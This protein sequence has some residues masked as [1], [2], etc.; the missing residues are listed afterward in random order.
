MKLL[1]SFSFLAFIFLMS[2][3]NSGEAQTEKPNEKL[4][5]QRTQKITNTDDSAMFFRQ[6]LSFQERGTIQFEGATHF[7]VSSINTTKI[8]TMLNALKERCHNLEKTCRQNDFVGD[9]FIHFKGKKEYYL[10][11]VVKC[12]K[13]DAYVPEPQNDIQRQLLSAYMT[14][15]RIN[16]TFLAA[17]YYLPYMSH[18][19]PRSKLQLSQVFRKRPLIK[20]GASPKKTPD[21]AAHWD[22]IADDKGT[23]FYIDKS[24]DLTFITGYDKWQENAYT[25]DTYRKDPIR[26][27]I[28]CIIVCQKKHPVLCR[29]ELK[30]IRKQYNMAVDRFIQVAGPNK[31]VEKVKPPSLY[32][33]VSGKSTK[34]S[35]PRNSSVTAPAPSTRSKRQIL[36]LAAPLLQFFLPFLNDGWYQAQVTSKLE[37]LETQ[38]ETLLEVMKNLTVP[39]GKPKEIAPVVKHWNSYKNLTMSVAATSA[40]IVRAVDELDDYISPARYHLCPLKIIAEI[41][42]NQEFQNRLKQR[43]LLAHLDLSTLSCFLLESTSDQHV[44]RLYTRVPTTNF[45]KYDLVQTLNVPFYTTHGPVQPFLTFEYFAV[46][47]SLEKVYPIYDISTCK[48]G[49]CPPPTLSYTSRTELC[50]V[51]QFY[52]QTLNTCVLQPLSNLSPTATVTPEGFAILSLPLDQTYTALSSCDNDGDALES[53]QMSLSGLTHL[54]IPRQCFVHIQT[55]GMTIR[56]PPEQFFSYDGNNKVS[57]VQHKA[58]NHSAQHASV[59]LLH[60]LKEQHNT[61]TTILWTAFLLLAGS[62]LFFTSF[63]IS[64][65]YCTLT[66]ARRFRNRVNMHLQHFYRRDPDLDPPTDLEATGIIDSTPILSQRQTY[67]PSTMTLNGRYSYASLTSMVPNTEVDNHVELLQHRALPAFEIGGACRPLPDFADPPPET[68]SSEEPKYTTI[69]KSRQLRGSS[70][71]LD[72]VK[73]LTPPATAAKPKMPGARRKL[74]ADP[75]IRASAGNLDEPPPF[76]E[77][78][79][80]MIIPAPGESTKDPKTSAAKLN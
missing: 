4:E 13:N 48:H 58:S 9:R 78:L 43:G 39:A 3:I 6:S 44:Y 34:S 27:D 33:T 10:K 61:T 64:Y 35:S 51:A 1:R 69:R 76:P 25:F 70:T 46:D 50:P 17:E 73:K 24:G 68:A 21:L 60:S 67:R 45:Q 8:V 12:E 2:T 52:N 77:P 57:N 37:T 23:S 42:E 53:N 31:D 49:I 7:T 20:H 16:T 29:D 54:F 74:Q 63:F 66:Y 75:R 14:K 59:I 38:Q 22:A 72:T 15:H 5:S 28:P 11:A 79:D 18:I 41:Q 56:G 55:L 32:V 19:Y 47:Q 30:E 80:A 65:T 36:S 71:A 26:S 62:C 40:A